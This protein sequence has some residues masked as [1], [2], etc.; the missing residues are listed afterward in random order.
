[1][2]STR[3]RAFFA[4]FGGVALILATAATAAAQSFPTGRYGSSCRI[5]PAAAPTLSPA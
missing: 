1:M 2:L 3:R 5:P 4:L